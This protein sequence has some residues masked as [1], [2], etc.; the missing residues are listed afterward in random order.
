MSGN[1][2]VKHYSGYNLGISLLKMLMCFLVIVSHIW[3]VNVTYTGPLGW[4]YYLREYS[5]PVFMIL[6]FF[7]NEKTIDNLDGKKLGSRIVKL[8]VPLW[9]WA[10]IY[11]VFYKL[12][13][14]FLYPGYEL[15]IRD[16]WWQMFTGNSI[17]LNG[18]MW[19][20]VDLIVLTILFAIIAFLARKFKN[21]VFAILSWA[22]ILLQYSGTLLF[23]YKWKSELV[24]CCGR[25]F[26]MLPMATI[27]FML[28]YFGLLEKSRK[29]WI[30]TMLI[31]IIAIRFLR[32][33]K[34]F[35]P[36]PV[37]TFDYGGLDKIAV[38]LALIFLFAAPPLEKLPKFVHKIVEW[39]TKYTLGIYCMHRLVSTLLHYFI[40]HRTWD[41]ETFTFIDCVAVYVISY[42]ISFLISLIP[43]KWTKM[44]VE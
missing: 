25:F 21:A 24:G 30:V 31:S 9:G 41:I 8:I 33:D 22:C 16:L 17:Y 35:A 43:C 29:N 7:F 34:P 4:L 23:I 11:W 44:M 38:G 6:T 28:A 14:E 15:R 13:E 12:L 18:T 19:F 39:L 5:V 10:V 42:L 32:Y 20:Q 1:T 26:E 37:Q 3:G 27:G 2:Y 36:V 40:S